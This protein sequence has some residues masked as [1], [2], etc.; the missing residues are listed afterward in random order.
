MLSENQNTE[1]KRE[2][3]YY[4]RIIKEMPVFTPFG[5][6]ARVKLGQL[7]AQMEDKES[8][9]N[10]YSIAAIQHAH[11]G[12]LVK[13]IAINNMII[14]LDPKRKDALARL[15]YLYFQRGEAFKPSTTSGK[16]IPEE[17]A[18]EPPD[19]PE[20]N[21]E[22]AEMAGG[23]DRRV[24][25][26]SH[27]LDHVPLFRH[28]DTEEL[29]K[30]AE[31]LF[32]MRVEKGMAIIKEG[33]SADCMYLITS[34]KV[35]VYTMLMVEDE[36][37]DLTLTDQKQLHLATLHA[38][39]FFGEQAL[40]TDEP[41]TATVI[42]LTDVHLLRF[43]KPDLEAIIRTYPRIRVL[44]QKYHQQRTTDTIEFLSAAFEQMASQA[45]ISA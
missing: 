33:E 23:I 26:F 25:E 17:S 14:E 37:S 32:P 18:P 44:L 38:S 12:M 40:V 27:D 2:I 10:E 34:G 20:S 7:Y 11:N 28:L 21:Q 24:K 39:D 45:R 19:Y 3:E 31:F 43:S 8:A 6:N 4:Q 36:K 35:G 42:A 16:T 41:R 15:S 9:I 30:I 29:Q 1:L 22:R 13:A 5:I